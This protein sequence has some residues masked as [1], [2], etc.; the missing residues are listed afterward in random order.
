MGL[1]DREDLQTDHQNGMRKANDKREAYIYI[2]IETRLVL[3][4]RPD[5]L[6]DGLCFD[7]RVGLL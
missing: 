2:G 3:I 1:L 7:R 6:L 4:K 5:L